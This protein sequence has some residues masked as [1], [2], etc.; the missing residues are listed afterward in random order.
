MRY[1]LSLF[2]EDPLPKL[3]DTTTRK[4]NYIY[5]NLYMNNFHQAVKH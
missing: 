2:W 4:G 3:L 1:R 5:A